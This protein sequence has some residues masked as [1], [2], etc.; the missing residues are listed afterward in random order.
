MEN[1]GSLIVSNRRSK[2]HF[3][4]ILNKFCIKIVRAA[5]Q[6]VKEKEKGPGGRITSNCR[7]TFSW[8]NMRLQMTYTER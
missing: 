3:R 2:L 6:Q 7:W 1:I 4:K 5:Q 8:V